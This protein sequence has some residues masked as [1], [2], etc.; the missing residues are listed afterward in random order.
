MELVKKNIHMDFIKAKA[1]TQLVLEDD[2]NLPDVK[3]DMDC[4]C[5]E[6]GNVVIEEAKAYADSACGIVRS[7]TIETLTTFLA[8]A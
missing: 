5:L 2:M 8:A 3:P 1:A 6:K 7:S 4:I